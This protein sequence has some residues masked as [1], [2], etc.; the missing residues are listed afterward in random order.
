MYS[1]KNMWERNITYGTHPC[2]IISSDEWNE[3]HST[4]TVIPCTSNMLAGTAINLKIDLG[5]SEGM[6]FM[7]QITTVDKNSLTNFWGKLDDD[8][9][10]RLDNLI[11]NYLGLGAT[12]SLFSLIRERREDQPKE[13]HMRPDSRSQHSTSPTIQRQQIQRPAAISQQIDRD[14]VR[15]AAQSAETV[16]SCKFNEGRMVSTQ[17]ATRLRNV[18]VVKRHGEK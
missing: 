14:A 17:R 5:N 8:N 3:S 12:D 15:E 9:M 18:F 6:V 2:I 7:S 10:N 13:I 4:V 11:Q 16:A 1:R